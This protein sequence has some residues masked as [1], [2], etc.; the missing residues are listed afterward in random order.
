MRRLFV[1]TS[2]CPNQVIWRQSHL[3]AQVLN[4][5]GCI[6]V[7][8]Q[9]KADETNLLMRSHTH[10]RF[11]PAQ[12]GYCGHYS[13]LPH[14]ARVNGEGQSQCYQDN[15]ILITQRV[16]D[17]VPCH[18]LTSG[19]LSWIDPGGS[20]RRS[21]SDSLRWLAGRYNRMVHQR[22]QELWR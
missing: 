15:S 8:I 21:C 9:Q 12:G 14:A 1:D 19:Q 4:G 5:D 6:I 22:S 17:S 10:R 13:I 20:L 2:E 7:S 11:F 3:T 16:M 18:R